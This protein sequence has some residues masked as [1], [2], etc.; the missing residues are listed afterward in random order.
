MGTVGDNNADALAEFSILGHSRDRESQADFLGLKLQYG[1]GLPRTAM[2]DM[3]NLLA[4]QGG[5]GLT[6]LSTH[7]ESRDCAAAANIEPLP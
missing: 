1:A 2:V 7:P 6:W 4:A 3:L 5:E